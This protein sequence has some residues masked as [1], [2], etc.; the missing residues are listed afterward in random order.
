MRVFDFNT[1]IVRT[2]GHSVVDGL[3]A[4]EGPSPS[5][6]TLLSEHTTYIRALQ[7]IGVQVSTLDPLE[8]YPDAVFVEDPALVFTDAA[9]LLR[10]GAKT[11]IGEI[12]ELAP[13]LM[14][15]FSKVLVQGEGYADGGDVLVTPQRVLI[16]LSARTN[17]LGAAQLQNLLETIG[18]HSAVV[19]PP[20]GTLHLK[21]GA[22]LIDE[23][24]ILATPSLAK[25]QIFE[26]YRVL[27]TPPDEESAANALRV[28][29]TVFVGSKYPRTAG[30]LTDHGLKVVTLPV[31][32]VGKIDA[33][34][35]CMSLRWFDPGLRR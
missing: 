6:P 15:R 13:E 11:R 3:R 20:R 26:G 5:Y 8:R 32:E 4:G 12:D 30:L 27:T 23:E 7:D 21:T 10:P 29:D 25:S 2:P 33:G 14:R 17:A 31:D 34:L 22:S 16:G 18:R 35:S 1:A 9:I 19:Q 24:T 28:N